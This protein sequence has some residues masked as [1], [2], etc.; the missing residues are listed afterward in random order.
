MVRRTIKQRKR[1]V[2]IIWSLTFLLHSKLINLD[3]IHTTYDSYEIKNVTNTGYDIYVY[4]VR[5]PKGINRVQ[6]PTWTTYGGQ[7][8]IQSSWSTNSKASGTN[9]GNGT[10]YYHV[11]ISDHNNEAGQYITH[12]YI[13]DNIGSL[14]GITGVTQV[15]QTKNYVGSLYL[16]DNNFNGTREYTISSNVIYSNYTYEF[17]A[18]PTTQTP[19]YSL[20]TYASTIKH[21]HNFIILDYVSSESNTAGMGLA[22]G[23]NGAV[24]IAHT[25]NYYY[26]LLSYT[27]DLSA[28]HKYRFTVN[29]ST[30][31]LYIDGILVATGISPIEPVTRISTYPIVCGGI[32]GEYYGEANNF[33]LY[34]NAR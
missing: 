9:L 25:G 15:V 1:K 3:T 18:K 16:S 4:G 21:T 32:Y 13:V 2:K 28:K 24:A 27:G 10:W 14:K 20:K 17:D 6:F 12:I 19:I 30:P 31:Y 22:L 34:N 5:T 11:N 29:N 7:D 33:V 26:V 8:D 23:T